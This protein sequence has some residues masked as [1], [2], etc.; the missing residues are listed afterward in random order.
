MTMNASGVIE[1]PQDAAADWSSVDW[2][3]IRRHVSRLQARFVKAVSG[4]W[5]LHGAFSRLEPCAVKV[6][7]TVLRGRDGGNVIPLPDFRICSL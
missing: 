6:A 2:T 3:K 1:G 7:C 4:R 5:V